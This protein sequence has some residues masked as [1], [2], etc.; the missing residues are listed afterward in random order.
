MARES[1]KAGGGAS[2]DELKGC[3]LLGQAILLEIEVQVILGAYNTW[4]QQYKKGGDEA[5]WQKTEGRYF[6]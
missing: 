1:K 4:I 6:G 2:M 5:V 3:H